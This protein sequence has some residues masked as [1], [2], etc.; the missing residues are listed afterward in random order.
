[1]KLEV[2][3]RSVAKEIVAVLNGYLVELLEIIEGSMT[4]PR[5]DSRRR[6]LPGP[7]QAPFEIAYHAV[8]GAVAK[9]FFPGDD[10]TLVP[11]PHFIKVF[12]RIP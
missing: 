8:R 12:F 6:P 7:L 2:R 9:P 3:W 4:I 11:V 1:M 10:E 5:E